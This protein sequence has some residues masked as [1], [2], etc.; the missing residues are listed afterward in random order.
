[1]YSCGPLHMTE[2]KQDNQ[3]EP[4]YKS[5]VPI[6]DVTLKTS[7]K[8][9]MIGRGGERGSGKSVLMARHDDGD[10]DDVVTRVFTSQMILNF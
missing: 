7:W 10:D 1:M 9:W 2:Q 6:H 8:Q 3:L 4:T 5:S